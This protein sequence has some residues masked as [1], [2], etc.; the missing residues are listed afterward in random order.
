MIQR[1][2]QELKNKTEYN[3][4][5]IKDNLVISNHNKFIME[6]H[7]VIKEKKNNLIIEYYDTVKNNVGEVS[8][9]RFSKN[10]NNIEKIIDFLN[11]YLS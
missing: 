11:K 5:N 4:K 7:V 2:K 6:E 8:N 9:K 3:I 1:L 10:N